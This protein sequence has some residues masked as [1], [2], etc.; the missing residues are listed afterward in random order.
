VTQ[1]DVALHP[2]LS[3]PCTQHSFQRTWYLQINTD[4]PIRRPFRAIDIQIP[5]PNLAHTLN[6]GAGLLIARHP[7]FFAVIRVGWIERVHEVEVAVSKR[8]GGV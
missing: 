1:A 2:H 3:A 7:D 5:K 4:P 8:A 6:N